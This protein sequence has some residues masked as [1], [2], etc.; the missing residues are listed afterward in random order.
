MIVDE[1]VTDYLRSLIREEDAFLER[2]EREARKNHVPIV[3]PETKEFLKLLVLM[4]QPM[5]IL[6]VGT[7]VGFSS[8]YMH[9]FQPEGGTVV[10]IE[11]NEGRILKAEANFAEAGVQNAVTLLKGDAV[12]I[13]KELSGSFDFIFMDAAQGQYIRFFEHILRLLPAG[14][15]LV[16]DNVLQDGD[17]VRSRYAVE[18]RDRTI[19]KRMREYLY[20]L[21]NHPLLETS[22]LP[23]GD[24][25]AVSMKT[26]E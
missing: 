21:K 26:G 19:H 16:S 18:R 22:V 25:V 7:A 15:I 4:K 9:K 23:V 3:K 8:L 20:T 12:Q 17:I 14:G 6:E 13:L 24:G 1:N 5:K 2:I 11:R 10:T